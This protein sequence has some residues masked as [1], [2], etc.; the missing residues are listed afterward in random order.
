[1]VYLTALLI[2][3]TITFYH[4]CNCEQEKSNHTINYPTEYHLRAEEINL[5]TGIVKP[6]EVWYSEKLD[7]YRS[8]YFGGSCKEYYVSKAKKPYGILYTT[9]PIATMDLKNEIVC[10]KV[11]LK[12][13]MENLL[14]DTENLEPNGETEYDGRKIQIWYGETTVLGI[15]GGR[16]EETLWTYRLADGKDVPIRYESKKSKSWNGH[17]FKH[18]I[19]NYYNFNSTVLLEDLTLSD[20]LDCTFDAKF[21][22]NLKEDLQILHPDIP[23]HV[24]LG[25]TSYLQHHKKKYIESEHDFRKD[26]FSHNWRHI[27]EHNLKNL[28]YKMA[29][30]EFSDRTDEEL[31]YLTGTRAPHEKVE[32][33]HPFPYTLEQVDALVEEL[34]KELDLRLEGFI[35][36]IKSQ[37]HCGSCWA[38]SSTAAVEGAI[39][40]SLGGKSF[41][42][43][44]QSLVDCAWGYGNEGCNGGMLDTAFEYIAKNGIPTSEDYGTYEELDDYCELE[45]VSSVHEIVGFTRVTPRSPNSLKVALNKY[46]PVAVAIHVNM[47]MKQ[48][49]SGIYYDPECQGQDINHG[50]TIIGYGVRDDQEYW[51]V[52]N[53]WGTDWGEG[54]YILMAADIDNCSILDYPYYA[55]V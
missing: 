42:L 10:N 54:G 55:I 16:V 34:P 7:R 2:W 51:I 53:S 3:F 14:P 26:I 36:P 33:T 38:F 40:K 9:H 15:V 50:V 23:S 5:V 28:S 11:K 27:R 21:G 43:S 6:F 13:S 8:D 32:G 49:S 52:R 1:M 48:Y 12:G 47:N 22:K 25:Y 45:N 31:K 4:S 29:I 46:G 35:R 18:T 30:N 19:T 20:D 39:A 24:N 41:D 44:E 17:I 37:G